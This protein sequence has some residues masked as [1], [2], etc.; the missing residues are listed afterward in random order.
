MTQP[1]AFRPNRGVTLSSQA[2]ADFTA[3]IRRSRREFGVEAAKRYDSLIRQAIED[4]GREPLRPSSRPQ[5]DIPIE[6]ARTYHISLSRFRLSGRT[7]RNPRH[8]LLY[9]CLDGN[10]VEIV[11]IL[12]DSRDL[13]RHVP[14]DE[15]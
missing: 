9:R 3:I 5:P 8:I 14:A 4:V 6:G 12:H 11:R 1:D 2:S 13:G 10:H 15:T 7:V